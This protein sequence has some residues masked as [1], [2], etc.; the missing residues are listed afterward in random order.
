MT[1]LIQANSLLFKPGNMT[2]PCLVLFSFDG[3]CN[4]DAAFMD[5]LAHRVFDF[6]N[7]SPHDPEQR[8]VAQLTT[9]ERAV[10]YRRR[11]LPTSFTGGPVAF[12]ADLWIERALLPAGFLTERRLP[13]LAEPGGEG[14][15]ELLPWWIAAGQENPSPR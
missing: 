5:T 12:V 13:C 9:N 4:N 7:T 11:P 2:L 1:T 15:L 14:A 8:Y 10:R 6:K 3:N